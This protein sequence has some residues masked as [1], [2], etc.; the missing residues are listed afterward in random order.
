VGD[1]RKQD[2]SGEKECDLS[3]DHLG[4]VVV[5]DRSDDCVKKRIVRKILAVILAL[6]VVLA[7]ASFNFVG[8]VEIENESEVEVE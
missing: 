6:G 1:Q 5:R 4:E 7:Y 2:L 3:G 8:N